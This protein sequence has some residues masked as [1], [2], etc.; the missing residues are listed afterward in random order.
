M[1]CA[2]WNTLNQPSLL[3]SKTKS[4]SLGS[5]SGRFRLISSPAACSNTS[6]WPLRSRTSP[7]TAVTASASVRFTRVVVDGAA[8]RFDRLDG[9]ERGV[10]PFEP[11]Q[12]A[13]DRHRRRVIARR[14]HPL[15]D[16]CL[17]RVLVVP[18][19]LE[20]GVVRIGCRCQIEQVE[21]AARGGGEVGS[22]RRHD[23]SG[24]TR[25]HEHRVRSEHHAVGGH[26][27]A[28]IA[29]GGERD[30]DERDTE[31]AV[32]D[33]TDLDAAGV[34]QRLLDQ[35]CS[36]RRGLAAGGQIDC[37]H[38]RVRPLLLVRL[39]EADDRSA[40]RVGGAA[41]VV[42]VTA[43]ETGCRHEEGA[44]RRRACA[45]SRRAP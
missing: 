7:I 13:F 5:L 30:L 40:E 37:L 43:A 20:V 41:V 25:D 18:E 15:G 26:H 32:V 39:R 42:T 16:R 27:V 10:E 8:C 22:D 4:N 11:T 23:A 24:R 17:E 35:L 12:L 6:M 19:R 31:A 3:T 21:R 36:D 44:R 14:L 29:P 28:I 2:A 1:S 45:W 9:S 34:E 33:A 38:Q